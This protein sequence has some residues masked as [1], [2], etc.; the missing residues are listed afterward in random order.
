M[1]RRISDYPDSYTPWN[2]ASSLGSYI[3]TVSALLFFVITF[4]TLTPT[5]L[6][7]DKE[8]SPIFGGLQGGLESAGTRNPWLN[9]QSEFFT[10]T[11]Q[12]LL[13]RSSHSLEWALSSPPKPHAFVSLPLQSNGIMEFFKK[14]IKNITLRLK[15]NIWSIFLKDAKLRGGPL[16]KLFVGASVFFIAKGWA[17]DIL[18]SI[19]YISEM[20]NVNSAVGTVVKGYAKDFSLGTYAYSMLILCLGYLLSNFT[21]NGTVGVLGVLVS[22]FYPEYLNDENSSIKD[23]CDLLGKNPNK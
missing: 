10:D 22:C 2:I 7:V 12:G 5:A 14:D 23:G 15:K 9:R 18:N 4:K 21:F 3:S 6:S 16:I 11:L 20:F 8:N 19:P 1:P 13:N 17:Y